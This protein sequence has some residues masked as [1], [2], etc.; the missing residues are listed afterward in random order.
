MATGMARGAAKRGKRIAFGD[1]HK[2]IWDQNSELI[3]RGNFN[4]AVPGTEQRTGVEWIPFYR[5]HRIYNDAETGRWRWNYDFHAQPG[6]VFLSAPE[7]KYAA[8]LAP[9]FV[10]IEPTVPWFKSVSANKQWSITRYQEV[11][12]RLVATGHDVAQFVYPKV[13]R[14]LGV[15]GI[16]TPDFRHALAAM[17]RAS[18]YIGPEGGLHHGAAAMGVPGVVLFGGF[19]PPSVTGYAVHTNLTG[20]AQACGSLRLCLHCIAAMKAIS[21][22]EVMAAA[23]AHLNKGSQ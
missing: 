10:L 16:R 3:F 7:K 23:V 11:A 17:S 5:G 6:E 22:D 2:I 19:I 12:R 13:T 20:G 9:G 14:I 15:R 1:G 21:V 18:L 4:I 8:G